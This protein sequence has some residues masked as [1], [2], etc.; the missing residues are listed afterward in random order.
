MFIEAVIDKVYI[1]FAVWAL[2]EEENVDGQIGGMLL[3]K[4]NLP[5]QSCI[6]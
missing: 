6:V 3:F 2:Q 4:K 5:K 1:S